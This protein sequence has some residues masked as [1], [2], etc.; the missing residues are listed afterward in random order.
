M[1]LILKPLASRLWDTRGRFCRA[2]VK[3]IQF[4]TLVCRFWYLHTLSD[5]RK[6]SILTGSK[7][8]CSWKM[9]WKI[10]GKILGPYCAL[11]QQGSPKY[12]NLWFRYISWW[13]LL[14]TVLLSWLEKKKSSLWTNLFE[15][16]TAFSVVLKLTVSAIKNVVF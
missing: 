11:A 3:S 9:Q 8:V 2:R 16:C 12:R 1:N 4:K 10:K 13:F 7:E 6:S 15:K 14:F 5:A